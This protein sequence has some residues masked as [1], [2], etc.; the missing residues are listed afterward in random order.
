MFK[1]IKFAFV[2]ILFSLIIITSCTKNKDIGSANEFKFMVDSVR[3]HSQKYGKD[4]AYYIYLELVDSIY[5]NYLINNK[6]D[7]I[8]IRSAYILTEEKSASN[9]KEAM[10]DLFELSVIAKEMNLRQTYGLIIN[11]RAKLLFKFGLY[12]EAIPLYLESAEIIRKN[13]DWHAYAY[14]LMDIGNTYFNQSIYDMA[15]MYYDLARIELLKFEDLKD[16]N[17]GLALYENNIALIQIEYQDAT[18]A[19]IHFRN[20]L[21][22][23]KQSGSENLYS[24]SYYY[25][26]RVKQSLGQIDSMDYYLNLAM[27]ID[28]SL[29][30][31]NERISS[32]RNYAYYLAHVIKNPEKSFHYYKVALDLINKYNVAEHASV[33]NLGIGGYYYR[34]GNLDSAIYYGWKADSIATLHGQS[35]SKGYTLRFLKRIFTETNDCEN[36]NKILNQTMELQ[37]TNNNS[38]DIL[39]TQ[40]AYEY[41][42][43]QNE[44]ILR[45]DDKK[46]HRIINILIGA[47]A[48]LLFLYTISLFRSRKKSKEQ[49]KKLEKALE[50]E[51]QLKLFQEDMTNMIIHD[52]KNPLSTIINVKYLAD[53]EIG[54]N[55]V[56]QSG[57]QM[58]LLIMNLLDIYKFNNSEINL[59][60]EETNIKTIIENA[61]SQVEFLASQ[62]NIKFQYNKEIHCLI[63]LDKEVIVRVLVNLFTNAIKYSPKGSIITINIE[64]LSEFEVKFSVINSGPHIPKKLHD[65]IFERFVHSKYKSDTGLRSTGLGLTYCKIAIE[66]HKGEIGVNSEPNKDV[67][68]WFTLPGLIEFK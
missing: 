18:A 49:S 28:S 7:S 62:R 67:E 52:L 39:K 33:I 2:N 44:I 9:P 17:Y 58:N 32:T 47:I 50:A 16:R 57:N 34:K 25:I 45:E 60:L 55:L 14:S 27:Q 11:T 4:T 37:S 31:V 51:K 36:L 23:R 46:R 61:L 65:I 59:H 41:E 35:H 15:I 13:K 68:F 54:L 30:L 1:Y 66:G 48:S 40:I 26:A 56:Q 12:N 43:K 63:N 38:D 22:Y 21:N 29:N 20:A 42:Q 10:D 8:Y 5:H 64:K 3:S 53:S 6:L 24:S 19:E